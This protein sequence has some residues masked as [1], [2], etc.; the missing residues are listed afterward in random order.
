MTTFEPVTCAPPRLAQLWARVRAA[1]R[2]ARRMVSGRVRSRGTGT[3]CPR[4]PATRRSRASRPSPRK[5][6][7]TCEPTRPATKRTSAVRGQH[8]RAPRP[9]TH[10]GSSPR[11]GPGSPWRRTRWRPR[12]S[13]TSADRGGNAHGRHP[14]PMSGVRAARAA[15]SCLHAA[16]RRGVQRP[17]Q[18]RAA[19]S[20]FAFCEPLDVTEVQSGKIRNRPLP[21]VRWCRRT[22]RTEIRAA[23][24]YEPVHW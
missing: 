21:L 24:A 5:G 23:R 9:A 13:R 7:T 3:I 12:R 2:T 19:G 18:C 4:S 20:H 1:V 14:V 17:R 22:V 10:P 16:R 15:R 11:S 6:T 8:P